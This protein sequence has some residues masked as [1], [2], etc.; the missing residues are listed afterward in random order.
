MKLIKF[1]YPCRRDPQF[2]LPSAYATKLRSYSKGQTIIVYKSAYF[3]SI[4]S[5]VTVGDRISEHF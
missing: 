1:G 2:W 5:L 3:N 4:R